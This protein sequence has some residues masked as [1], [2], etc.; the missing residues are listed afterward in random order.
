L[1]S[2]GARITAAWAPH[3]AKALDGVAVDTGNSWNTEYAVTM[4]AAEAIPSNFKSSEVSPTG[5]AYPSLTQRGDHGRRNPPRLSRRPANISFR[6]SSPRGRNSNHLEARHGLRPGICRSQPLGKRWRPTKC[7]ELVES[8][9]SG[10]GTQVDAFPPRTGTSDQ[11]PFGVTRDLGS[12][13]ESPSIIPSSDADGVG[14]GRSVP[15]PQ[16]VQDAPSLLPLATQIRSFD[17][18]PALGT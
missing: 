13:T 5:Q 2:T 11:F 1:A 3:G 15:E 7:R 14:V 10:G 12:M 8:D 16:C 18:C 6:P 9:T 4:R 17:R